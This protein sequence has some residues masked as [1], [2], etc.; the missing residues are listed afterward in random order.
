MNL[1]AVRPPLPDAP[2]ALAPEHQRTMLTL[3]H[4]LLA[5]TPN[6][7]RSHPPCMPRVCFALRISSTCQK[8]LQHLMMV[9]HAV[10]CNG[11]AEC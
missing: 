1:N 4:H 8:R 6:V 3:A 10:S 5:S 2:F 11:G 7:T 9:A